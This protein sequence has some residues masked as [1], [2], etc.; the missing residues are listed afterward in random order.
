MS[1]QGDQTHATCCAQQCCDMLRWHV[2]IV[3]PGLYSFYSVC[4]R[5]FVF[6]VLFSNFLRPGCCVDSEYL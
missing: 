6:L 3:R 2:A 4:T 1:Q 5:D